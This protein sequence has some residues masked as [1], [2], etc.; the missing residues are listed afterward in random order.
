VQSDLT[1]FKADT[2]ARFD[3]VD[4]QFDKVEERFKGV[5]KTLSE[6]KDMISSANLWAF[7][8]YTGGAFTLLFVIGRVA[9]WL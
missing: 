5:D 7:G 1:E 3:K 9:K 2:K 6:I 4:K 8:L